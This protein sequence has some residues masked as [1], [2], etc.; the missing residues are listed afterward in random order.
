MQNVEHS[1]HST[2]DCEDWTVCFRPVK[3]DNGNADETA[4]Y[5]S[6]GNTVL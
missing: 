2:R 1:G 5:A 6:K 4:S 3:Y